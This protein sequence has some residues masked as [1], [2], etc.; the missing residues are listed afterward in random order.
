MSNSSQVL[1]CWV[2]FP[3]A[4]VANKKTSYIC[5]DDKKLSFDDRMNIWRMTSWSK[6]K[7]GINQILER[8]K[9]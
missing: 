1:T 6:L 3:A 9:M 5:K 8:K 2:D 4:Y 7:P